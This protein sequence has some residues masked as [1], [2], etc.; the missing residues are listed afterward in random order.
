MVFLGLRNLGEVR[1][2]LDNLG[3]ELPFQQRDQALAHAVAGVVQVT[4]AGI[5]SPGLAQTHQIALN[6]AT[7]GVQQRANNRAPRRLVERWPRQ[8]RM[9]SAKATR[10]GAANQA[11]QNGFSLVVKGMRGSDLSRQ[12][13]LISDQKYS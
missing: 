10:A 3:I 9:N 4:V 8:L 13:L 6:F 11:K 5:L 2:A 12:P 7:A 1:Q